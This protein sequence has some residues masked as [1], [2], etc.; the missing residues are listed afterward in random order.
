MPDYLRHSYEHIVTTSDSPFGEDPL[1]RVTFSNLL[2][3]LVANYSNGFVMSVNGA[4]GTGK[5]VF[6]HQW[7]QTLLNK[8][9]RAT[10]LNAWDNDYFGEPT[11]AI[12]SQF[13]HFFDAARPISDKGIAIWKTL[14]NVPECVI[15]GF[16]RKSASEIIGESAV[17]EIKDSYHSNLESN[18]NYREG[19]IAK[20][21]NQRTS[22]I[23][24]KTALI[25][26]AA[27]IASEGKPLVFVIDE[28][29]RCTPSYAI[30]ILEK[31][32][33]LFNIP[34]IIFCLSIDKEQLKKTIQ[35]HYGSYNFNSEEYL[36]RFFDVEFELPPIRYEEFADLMV[37]H[38]ELNQ[39][40]RSKENLREFVEVSTMMAQKQHLTLR[41]LEKFYAHSKLVFSF[42]NTQ[43]SEW[44]I[45]IMLIIHK[46]DN[47]LFQNIV[48][49][50]WDLRDYASSLKR[51][52]N[53]EEYSKGANKLG[54]LL[55]HIQVYLNDESSINV[56]EEFKLDWTSDFSRTQ[57][58]TMTWCYKAESKQSL[59]T[60]S[61][62]RII[63]KI[64]FIEQFV[65]RP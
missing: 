41:Q 54:C 1:H 26:F 33:H 59:R 45:G 42:Y 36:R 8:G 35:G 12:L 24:Y 11:L 5:T 27:T 43:D 56:N 60:I 14:Q 32:K 49:R 57:L 21:I 13:R 22:F 19:D 64:C 53:L 55:Y 6:M 37:N 3:S 38:Y 25:D 18:I 48:D 30:E 4:W 51:L 17:D 2:T 29:D 20:Y 7:V 34:N 52:F 16:I 31:I 50:V 44:L 62:K 15:K 40:I 28:L 65:A 9:Y 63:E 58:D 47:D 39:L 10:I 46:F 61:L 23:E